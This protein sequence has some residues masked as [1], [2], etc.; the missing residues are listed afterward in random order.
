MS[1]F[2]IPQSERDLSR[3]VFA[4][5]QLTEGRMNAVGRVTLTANDTST[6]VSAPTCGADSSVFLFPATTNAASVVASTYVA[7]TDVTPGQFVVT[8][9][10]DAN[11][12][13]TF[14][15]V[16]LG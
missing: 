12:D 8:H 1:G 9:P 13:K 11:S 16:A 3:V 15:W 7:T 14:Y 5:R 10:S 4:V 6:T 2:T